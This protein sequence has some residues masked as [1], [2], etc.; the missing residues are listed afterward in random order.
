MIFQV[1]KFR[2]KDM[3]A[4]I[5]HNICHTGIQKWY[6]YYHYY[7]NNTPCS[8]NQ[9]SWSKQCASYELLSFLKKLSSPFVTVV[10]RSNEKSNFTT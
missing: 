10:Q 3:H 1:V 4:N 9:L 8:V 7:K 5:K 2:E 6:F